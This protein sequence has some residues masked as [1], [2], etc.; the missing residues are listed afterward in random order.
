MCP[1]Q[2]QN[3]DSS[4]FIANARPAVTDIWLGCLL[5]IGGKLIDN[6]RDFPTSSQFPRDL[7]GKAGEQ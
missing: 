7:L 1:V 6:I 5:W 3:N 2:Y 4:N